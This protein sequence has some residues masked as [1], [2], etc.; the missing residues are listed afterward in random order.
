MEHRKYPLRI[1]DEFVVTADPSRDGFVDYC[2]RHIAGPKMLAALESAPGHGDLLIQS[3]IRTALLTGDLPCF[4]ALSRH[5]FLNLPLYP[6]RTVAGGAKCLTL[7]KRACELGK[8][9]DIDPWVIEVSHFRLRAYSRGSWL[10][11]D[12]FLVTPDDWLR[13]MAVGLF[14]QVFLGA[15]GVGELQQVIEPRPQNIRAECIAALFSHCS[16]VRFDL[17]SGR[18][19]WSSAASMNA[20]R[21]QRAAEFALTVA[22][23]LAL[24]FLRECT[25]RGVTMLATLVV[26]ANETAG[27]GAQNLFSTL[28]LQSD[29]ARFVM[30]CCGAPPLTKEEEDTFI[31]I[32]MERRDFLLAHFHAWAASS[33]YAPRVQDGVLLPCERDLDAFERDFVEEV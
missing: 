21:T 8:I 30:P 6:K 4:Q 9:E 20:E 15:V 14:S 10:Q 16:S 25:G 32:N 7:L 29:A 11:V 22:S 31:R 33:V 26:A 12:E 24:R 1:N 19:V 28:R 13:P 3:C 23:F 17:A 27:P 2:R 5:F 18:A